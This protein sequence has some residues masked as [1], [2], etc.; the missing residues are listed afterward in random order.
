MEVM[1]KRLPSLGSAVILMGRCKSRATES[2]E[3][4]RMLSLR[5]CSWSSRASEPASPAIPGR[6]KFWRVVAMAGAAL[7]L[8][9]KTRTSASASSLGV[10]SVLI[11]FST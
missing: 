11:I 7:C 6:S 5:T 9:V 10:S 3:S 4:L 8:R 2:P 1:S